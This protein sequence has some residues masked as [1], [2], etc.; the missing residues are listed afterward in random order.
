MQL[1]N[2]GGTF[3]GTLDYIL[4]TRSNMHVLSTLE[5]PEEEDI[6]CNKDGL[7]NEKYSSDHVAL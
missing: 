4:Y 2:A 1:T 3:K 6:L 7:P 5:L